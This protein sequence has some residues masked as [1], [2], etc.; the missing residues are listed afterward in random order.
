MLGLI[1]LAFAESCIRLMPEYIK[2]QCLGCL[3][4]W[5]IFK[6]SVNVTYLEE[7]SAK[8]MSSINTMKSEAPE[9]VLEEGG[10]AFQ[11]R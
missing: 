3:M 11:N 7:L 10:E 6:S 5:Q 1:Y 9:Q 4:A 8:Y 2:L